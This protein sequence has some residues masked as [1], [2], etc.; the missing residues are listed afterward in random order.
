[1]IENAGALMIRALNLKIPPL[2]LKILKVILA[3][4]IQNQQKN[5]NRRLLKLISLK[6][7]ESKY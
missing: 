7:K 3:I 2:C 1:M 6:M 4:R 5:L